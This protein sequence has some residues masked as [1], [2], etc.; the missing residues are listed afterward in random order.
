MAG[1]QRKAASRKG[2]RRKAIRAVTLLHHC[3]YPTRGHYPSTPHTNIAYRH[4]D[5]QQ[6]KSICANDLIYLCTDKAGYEQS[7]GSERS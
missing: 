5:L 2:E 7:S 1:H 6:S 4:Q 3:S